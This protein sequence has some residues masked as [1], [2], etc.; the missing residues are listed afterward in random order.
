MREGLCADAVRAK[1][2]KAKAAARLLA[3]VA[4]DAAAAAAGADAAGAGGRGP[5][6]PESELFEAPEPPKLKPAWAGNGFELNAEAAA[7]RLAADQQAAARIAAQKTVEAQ[8][9]QFQTEFEATAREQK[10][11]L[12]ERKRNRWQPPTGWQR[13]R[14]PE[15]GPSLRE[16]RWR[17]ANRRHATQPR[18]EPHPI[19]R[20]HAI[21]KSREFV[22]DFAEFEEWC[23][24]W[25]A[26]GQPHLV[27]DPTNVWGAVRFTLPFHLFNELN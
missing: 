9:A 15:S 5:G 27:P 16:L 10:L 18:T 4:W 7:A 25:E 14:S 26:A 1:E 8:T 17:D 2:T 3:K 21:T 12:A 22:A 13:Q 11:L 24:K 19:Q 6:G 20:P 23:E